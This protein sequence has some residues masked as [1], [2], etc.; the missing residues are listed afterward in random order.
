[1]DIVHNE[2]MDSVRMPPTY[3]GMDIDKITQRFYLPTRNVYENHTQLCLT[4]HLSNNG[5]K[6]MEMVN[7]QK[8]NDPK[9]YIDIRKMNYRICIKKATENRYMDGHKIPYEISYVSSVVRQVRDD[10]D[11]QQTNMQSEATNY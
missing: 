1:M 8:E 6:I 3:F 7:K 11:K 5:H 9:I 10:I 4:E 2:C